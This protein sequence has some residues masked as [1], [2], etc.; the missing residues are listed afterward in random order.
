VSCVTE[1]LDR[2][3]CITHTDISYSRRTAAISWSW[4]SKMWFL[5]TDCAVAAGL[6]SQGLNF[7]VVC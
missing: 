5:I 6:I 3:H 2:V 1:S 7:T 4:S